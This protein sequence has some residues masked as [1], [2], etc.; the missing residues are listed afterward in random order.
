MPCVT[1]CLCA[2]FSPV[3]E[4]KEVIFL[5]EEDFFVCFSDCFKG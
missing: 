4:H 1:G 2:F 3:C 5:E